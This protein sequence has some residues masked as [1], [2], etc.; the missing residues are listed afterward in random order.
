MKNAF[1]VHGVYGSPNENWFPWISKKLEALGWEV[2]V[3]QFPTPEGHNLQ[4]WLKVWKKYQAFLNENSIVVGHSMGA[5]FL[6]SVLE[7]RET[8]VK[9]TFFIAGFAE[10]L[11]GDDEI[12]KLNKSFIQKDFNWEK[13][14]KNGGKF[15]VFQSDNDPYVSL[16]KAKKLADKLDTE[17]ILVKNAGHF[18]KKA[19]YT[20]FNLLLS[21]IKQLVAG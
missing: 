21:K 7:N 1:I 13:I 4:N 19:G 3:P 20:Q 12:N 16:D 14:R 11:E 5:T 8:P 2:F 15:F 17:I 6:L 18:N 9:A 10:F